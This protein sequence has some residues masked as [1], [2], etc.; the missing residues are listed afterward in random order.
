MPT[1]SLLASKE[2]FALHPPRARFAWLILIAG[3]LPGCAWFQPA[4]RFHVTL[5][6]A[7][8]DIEHHRFPLGK[9][10]SLVG[11]L[12]TVEV[13]DGDSLADIAR[14]YGLGHEQIG[15]ANPGLDTWV[16]DAGRRAVLPLQFVL[17][18]APRR[19]I[20]VNL[21]AMRLFAFPGKT[22]GGVVTYPVGIGREGR[23]TPTGDMY[24]DRKTAQ[25]TWY[26]PESIRRDHA[27]KGDPL[28]AAVSPGPDN[29]LGEYAMY[30]SRPSY[31]IHGTNKPYAIGFRASNGCLRLYPEDIKLLFQATPVKTP[32]RIINQP[33]LLG[34]QD[35]QLYLEAHAPHEELNEKALKKN[36]YAKLK[37]IEK[38]QGQTLDWNKIEATLT[39]TRG[40]PVPVLA[41]S[42]TVAQ[43]VR[44]AVALAPPDELYGQPPAPPLMAMGENW[45]V[46][47]LETGDELTARRTAAVLN[48]MGPQIPA[49]AMSLSGG[50]YR[51]VAGPFK[52]GKAAQAM[53][54][55]LRIELE[56][57]GEVVA[58]EARLSAR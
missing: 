45:F 10:D 41:N 55:R 38:K 40:I 15:A 20:V 18:D 27:R 53:A 28:P 51:V 14:H 24:V 35:D 44:E 3:L 37:D 1:T 52:D 39:E 47:A 42:P 9:D 4:E 29:P 36:L 56:M 11:Q 31:L 13:R 58:P 49:R 23:S 34:W 22:S 46:T 17:P 54:K 8:E 21:A 7:P 5:P 32:V 48:H 43:L 30:L 16:P 6:T 26:V 33:Y 57:D 12:A 19:G 2:S 50:R 25:P